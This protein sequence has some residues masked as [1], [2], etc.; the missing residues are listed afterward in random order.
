[1][2]VC[3]DVCTYVYTYVYMCA[4]LFFTAY[5]SADI[6]IGMLVRNVCCG[7]HIARLVVPVVGERTRVP[8]LT[9]TLEVVATQHAAGEE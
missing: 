1:M 8:L 5:T 7:P 9:G 4:Y 3:M 2:H 6:V